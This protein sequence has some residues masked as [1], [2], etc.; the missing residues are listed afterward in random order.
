MALDIKKDLAL[1][2][3]EFFNVKDQK[4]GICIHHTVG[5]SAES[6]Y[7]W[8]R[9][10]SQMVGTAYLI[11]RDGTLYQIFDP[12]NWAWQFGLPWEY[13]DKI[14]FEKRFIGIEL[15]SEGGILEQDGIYYCFDRVSPK[16][17]KPA[18]EIFDAGMDYRGYR[19]FDQY[20]PEQVATLIELINTLCDRFDIP[21]RVPAEPM[22]YYGQELKGFHGII[23]H[24][25]VRKDKSDP[26][27][28]PGFWDQL[29][30]GCDLE[31]IDTEK[32]RPLMENQTMSEQEIDSLFEENVK[33]L[34]KMNVSAGSMVKGLI[35]ELQRNNRGTYIRLRNAVEEG[36]QISY[37]FV[38]GD[39]S[40]VKRIGTALGFKNITKN[41]MEVR[42]G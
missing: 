7:N 34:N 29:R 40:L 24:A 11:G 4:S 2:E 14:V 15:A 32:D 17:V 42:N 6:T 33:E 28:M 8:W 19:I 38:E 13:E 36:H 35:Q 30:N 12:E 31:F 1:P 18:N 21:R 20:E 26:A 41:K 25:M 39:K 27:P 23:G 5:G 37:D 3:M 16:T 10:D 22:N 9:N